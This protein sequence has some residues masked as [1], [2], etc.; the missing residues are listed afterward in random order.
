MAFNFPWENSGNH[1]IAEW[2]YGKNT[3]TGFPLL[4]LYWLP[5]A[6][7]TNDH[8]LG[9]LKNTQVFYF[10]VPRAESEIHLSG[11]K[12]RCGQGC[13]P[14]CRLQGSTQF[15]TFSIFWKPSAFLGSWSLVSKAS[16][17]LPFS[18]SY[19]VVSL[20]L[21]RLLPYPTFKGYMIDYIRSTQVIQ[22]HLPVLQ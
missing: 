16:D 15:L 14:L 18:L 13:V 6:A 12:L 1:S 7:I 17:D 11:L 21:T 19:S 3:W 8:K 4:F 9:G 20:V 5:T 22:D 10:K 2:T